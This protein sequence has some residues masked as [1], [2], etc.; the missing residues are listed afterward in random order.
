MLKL[1]KPYI[2]RIVSQNTKRNYPI[3]P[4]KGVSVSDKSYSQHKKNLKKKN[5][6]FIT[7][8]KY[9]EKITVFSG[10]LLLTRSSAAHL[11]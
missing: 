11:S 1:A 2:L 7:L 5:P 9:P 4:E 6:I 3:L 8:S 10:K